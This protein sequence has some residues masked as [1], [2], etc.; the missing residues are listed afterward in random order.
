MGDHTITPCHPPQTALTGLGS[1]D[2]LHLQPSRLDLPSGEASSHFE[3]EEPELI[4]L[5]AQVPIAYQE[6]S[7]FSFSHA[8]LHISAPQPDYYLGR[9]FKGMTI[10]L[11]KLKHALFK[12][13]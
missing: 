3:K 7:V 1:Q 5:M 13:Y 9:F 6:Q 11:P 12:M 4:H 8:T 2:E 10:S